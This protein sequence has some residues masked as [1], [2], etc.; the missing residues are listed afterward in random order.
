MNK[1]QLKKI[2]TILIVILALAG[3]LYGAVFLGHRVFFKPPA[4]ESSGVPTI[5]AAK[6]DEFLL[7]VQAHTKPADIDGYI[8]LLAAQIKRYNESAPSLWPD[9]AV[10]NR[11]VMVE[12]IEDKRFWLISPDGAV[13][14]LTKNEAQRYGIKRVPRPDGFSAFKDGE[15]VA[16]SIKAFDNVLSYQR[17]MHLGTYDLFST[18]AHESF[19]DAEQI[20]WTPS[21]GG[22]NLFRN[23]FFGNTPARVLRD[24]LQRQLMRAV[25]NPEDPQLILDAL[26][27]YADYKECFP[28]EYAK[29]IDTDRMEGTAYYHELV[30]CLYAAYPNINDRAALHRALALLAA[31]EDVYVVHGLVYEGY[32]VGGLSCVL[33]DRL[34]NDDSWKKRLITDGNVTP[35]DLLLEQFSGQ[36]L[37]KPHQPTQ[38]EIDAVLEKTQ[39]SGSNRQ[40]IVNV[41]QAL[42]DFL[43]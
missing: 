24:I 10:A 36:E 39:A 18:F 34:V 26:A 38:A 7:G 8:T 11:S 42:Y 33:L 2:K 21:G 3:F 29:S 37:P 14:P 41:F 28:E 6:N 9:N 20:K 43:F 32:M 15:Y 13:T 35:A 12:C 27:T 16:A 30:S 17:Y 31:R 19:H 4:A 23:E 40:T 1:K 25:A 22:S 5:E